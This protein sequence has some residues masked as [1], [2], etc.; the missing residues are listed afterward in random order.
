MDLWN[1]T[2]NNRLGVDLMP[3][4]II[5]DNKKITYDDLGEGIPIL[6]IHPP[7][8]GR[9]VFYYQRKLSDKMRVIIPDLTGHGDSSEANVNDLS[10][11][12]YSKEIL[13]LLDELKIKSAVLCGYSAGGGI[14]Q[15]IS[16]H[17]QERVSGLILIGGF[18]AVLNASLKVEHK[19]GMYMVKHHRN[20]LT[21]ILANSHTKNKDLKELLISHMNKAQLGAWYKFYQEVLDMK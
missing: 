13:A 19:L 10:I 6:F 5:E 21:N 17:Y 11:M 15:I 16:S 20:L 18:P 2:S 14:A 1:N 8:M 4:V 12:Y 3:T 7:G 9:H